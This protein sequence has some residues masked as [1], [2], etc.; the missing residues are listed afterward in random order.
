MLW[1]T[2][3]FTIPSATN[4]YMSSTLTV[5]DETTSGQ[6]STTVRLEFLKEKITVQE[7]IRERIYQEVQDYNLKQP[8]YFGSGATD[9]GREN[10]QRI[11]DAEGAED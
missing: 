2:K 3:M 11:Q 6:R 10:A 7:L 4:R 1:R 5:Y 8:E 9:R